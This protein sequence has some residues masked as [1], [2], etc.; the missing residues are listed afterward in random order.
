M[1]MKSRRSRKSIMS[2]KI[3]GRKRTRRCMRSMR[4]RK[5]IRSRRSIM[6]RSRSRRTM[7]NRWSMKSFSRIVRRRRH[8]H[9]L[10]VGGA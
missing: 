2:S 6:S 9:V 7:M 3:T 10:E 8:M 4:S 5:S 1:R